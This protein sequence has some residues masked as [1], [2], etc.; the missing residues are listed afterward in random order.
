MHS[1]FKCHPCTAVKEGGITRLYLDCIFYYVQVE[2]DILTRQVQTSP[3]KLLFIL[4]II[5]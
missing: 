1:I 3:G 5:T 2:E 4:H